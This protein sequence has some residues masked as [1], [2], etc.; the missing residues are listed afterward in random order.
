MGL[1]NEALQVDILM[2]N[3]ANVLLHLDFS[4]FLSFWIKKTFMELYVFDFCHTTYI[5]IS[6]GSFVTFV[7]CPKLIVL[8]QVPKV[9]KVSSNVYSQV[10]RGTTHWIWVGVIILSLWDRY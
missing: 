9:T 3:I 1:A 2:P 7:P 4:E 10:F 8:K 6:Y 5:K